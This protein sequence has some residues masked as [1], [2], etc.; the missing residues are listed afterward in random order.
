MGLFKRKQEKRAL[1]EGAVDPVLRALLAQD[2]TIS[3]KDALQVPMVAAC[4]EWI[5]GTVA[6]L[7]VCLYR[8]NGETVTQVEDDPRVRM[9]NGD[10]GDL[11]DAYQMKKAWCRDYLLSGN[12]Y[13]YIHR[14]RNDVDGL[15]Y[16]PV[17]SISA[18]VGPDPIFKS[19]SIVVNGQTYRPFDFI[20]IL[21]NTVDGVNGKGILD[22]NPLILLVASQTFKYQ[23][24]LVKAGGCRKGFLLSEKVVAEGI[25]DKLR[26]A[27]KRLFS[28]DEE[29]VIVL[30]NGIKFQEASNTSVE[31]QMNE[32]KQSDAESIC[33]LF[34]LSP[35]LFSGSISNEQY[36]N[37][38]RT[39]ISPIL[40]AMSQAL[41]L[42]LLLEVEKGE[43]FWDFDTRELLK[44]DMEKRFSAYRTAVEGNIM[45]IDE[46]RR[47]E[48]LPA[49]GLDFIKMGLQDVL[50]NPKSGEIFIPN[51]GIK[52]NLNDTQAENPAM[53]PEKPSGE[54]G[55]QD[56]SGNSQ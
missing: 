27:W 49:L 38:I 11:M 4:V 20:R 23:Y 18:S 3:R 52:S 30:N 25:M 17:S 28:S 14:E 44:V 24:K 43:Y 36:N 47:R 26:E 39:A 34:G 19:A 35:A 22:E 42:S 9:L 2:E 40:A 10:T 5:T 6:S 8:R 7:P 29:N 12:G 1:D 45:Q 33:N 37:S 31:M 56:E 48:N 50:Y 55:E 41:N 51:M 15:Y 53:L 54:G 21:R 32:N 16:V 46:V 13:I